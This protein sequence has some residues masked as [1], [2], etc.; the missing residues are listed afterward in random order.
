MCNVMGNVINVKKPE[1][2][3]SKNGHLFSEEGFYK[4]TTCKTSQILWTLWF[5]RRRANTTDLR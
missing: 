2:N 3:Q 5:G 1:G 4:V